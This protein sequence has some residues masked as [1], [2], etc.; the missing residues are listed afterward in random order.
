MRGAQHQ[1]SSLAPQVLPS[2]QRAFLD[3]EFVVQFCG[4]KH[5]VKPAWDSVLS[6]KLTSRQYFLDGG[7]STIT[8]LSRLSK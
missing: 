1:A 3:D 8:K 7:V 5:P 4:S 6:L 2:A